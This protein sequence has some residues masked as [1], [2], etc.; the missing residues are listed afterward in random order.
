LARLARK[1]LRETLRDRRTIITLVVMPV[2]VYPLLSIIFHQFL[3]SGVNSAGQPGE[4]EI[5]L[6]GVATS[7]DD[8]T[9]SKLLMRAMEAVRRLPRPPADLLPVEASVET[10]LD[11]RQQP[12]NLVIEPR[13]DYLNRL[14]TKAIDVAVEMRRREGEN[15]P[16]ALVL[17]F[18]PDSPRSRQGAD[19][20]QRRLRA[21]NRGFL[22]E[23]MQAARVPPG[24]YVSVNLRPHVFDEPSTAFSLSALIPVVLVLMTVTG[25]V[26]PAIDL[27]AGERERNTLECLIAAPITRIQLLLAKYVAVLTVALLTA[28]VNLLGMVLTLRTTGVGQK[29]L[30]N[31][32]FTLSNLAA[33]LALLV[34]FAAFYSAVLL[35][36][37][38]FARSFKE[39]QAYLIPLMLLSLGPALASL[40]PGLRLGPLTSITPLIN[41]VLLARDLLGQE[42]SSTDLI[43]GGIAVVS[44]L[45]YAGAA[46][47]MAARI[48]G[49]DSILYGSE[50]SWS[51]LWRRPARPSDRPTPAMLAVCFALLFPLYVFASG[52]LGQW[53]DL[54]LRARLLLNATVTAALFVWLPTHVAALRNVRW[55]SGFW[56][57]AASPWALLGGAILGLSLWPIAHELVLLSQRLGLANLTEA[58]LMEARHLVEAFRQLPPALVLFCLAL[59]PAICEELFFRGFLLSSL[60]R[61]VDAAPAI[62][63]SAVSFGLFHVL[64][65]HLLTP[66]RLFSS[67]FLGLFLAWV[68]WR[69]KSVLPGIVLHAVNN[70]LLLSVALFSRDLE[71]SYG[72]G[73]LETRHLP[74]S[75]LAGSVLGAAV[76]VGLVWLGGKR[77]TAPAADSAASHS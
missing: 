23:K 18:R 33:V 34:L 19:L 77:E 54:D 21:L 15:E 24:P 60:A 36:I 12:Q 72:L 50:Q 30:G 37:T 61:H 40:M 55:K 35:A 49:S 17:H 6:V 75:W 9:L 16:A 47:T 73:G 25:A 57:Q 52:S 26:Y 11:E 38:S 76:G 56:W 28:G 7:E 58:R 22:I 39:A 31:G 48:F 43:Y 64:A 65:G 5:I 59:T 42:V 45:L 67:T 63:I 29:L 66:E 62:A 53:S 74:A 51:D 70:G 2:L 20:I 13:P 3:L 8:N 68:A 14:Q 71:G 4:Q 46:L 1:E 32:A 41:V 69:T 27:T 44:T 10:A